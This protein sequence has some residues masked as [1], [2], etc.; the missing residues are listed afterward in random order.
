MEVF[1][2]LRITDFD[3]ERCKRNGK[4]CERRAYFSNYPV[5]RY[6]HELVRETDCSDSSN[7]FAFC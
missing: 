4:D 3:E 2:C 1:A 7:R 5:A 6:A